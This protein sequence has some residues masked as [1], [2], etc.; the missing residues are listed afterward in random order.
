MGAHIFLVG[1]DNFDVCIE[2]G[3]YGCV[4][5]QNEWNKAEIIAGV[6]GIQPEDLVSFYV[7]NR[8]VY[9]LWKVI[10]TPYFDET[11]LWAN[12]QQLFP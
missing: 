7:K 4:M 6:F 10:G 5:P 11:P 1:A 12:D 2:N 9:G 3:V 8:G